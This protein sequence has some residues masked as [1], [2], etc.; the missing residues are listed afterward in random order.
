MTGCTLTH[1]LTHTHRKIKKKKKKKR[2]QEY[3]RSRR[4]GEIQRLIRKERPPAEVE[5]E[6]KEMSDHKRTIVQELPK[7]H[8]EKKMSVE[9]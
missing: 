4:E 6:E 3:R 5:E 8:R 7:Y 9:Q 2:E 1:S